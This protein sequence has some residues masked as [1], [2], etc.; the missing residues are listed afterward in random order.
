MNTPFR[1]DLRVSCIRQITD[2]ILPKRFCD[3]LCHQVIAELFFVVHDSE[4]V[5]V[6]CAEHAFRHDLIV[7]FSAFDDPDGSPARFEPVAADVSSLDDPKGWREPLLEDLRKCLLLLVRQNV[8]LAKL[9]KHLFQNCVFL[10]SWSHASLWENRMM[11]YD[12]VSRKSL[13]GSNRD[14]S[15]S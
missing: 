11:R 4:V 12:R 8:G 13:E 1:G 2:R 10:G 7:A 15:N 3:L 14:V 6:A 9:L 5:V